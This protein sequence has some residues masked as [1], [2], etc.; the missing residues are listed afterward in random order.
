[1]TKALPII[2]AAVL[3]IVP[4]AKAEFNDFTEVKLNLEKRLANEGTSQKDSITIMLNLF[5]IIQSEGQ[6]TDS[7]TSAVLSTA[8]RSKDYGTAFDMLNNKANGSYQSI[9][10]L[11]SL[12]KIAESLPDHHRKQE[13]ISF[14]EMS[15]NY[16]YAYYADNAKRETRFDNQLRQI[17]L[18]PPKDLYEHIKVLHAI[19]LNLAKETRSDLT[20]KYF[21]DLLKL[22]D[23]APQD[24]RALR[25][26]ALVQAAMAFAVS[27]ESQRA[28]DADLKL[29]KI[30]EELKHEYNK[31]G[32][33]YRSFAPNKYI[34]YTRLLSNWEHLTPAQ[35]D[36]F[37]SEALENAKVDTRA[38]NTY[39]RY[40]TP[41][42]YYAMAHKDYAKAQQLIKDQIDHPYNAHRKLQ[43]LKYLITTSQALGDNATTLEA[44]LE[45]NKMLEEQLQTRIQEKY[46]ELQIVYETNAMREQITA[47][48]AEAK[49]K[50]ASFQHTILTICLI[51]L[52]GLLILLFFLVRQYRHSKHLT[53][54]LL[55]SNEAL[56]SE[57]CSLRA[58]QRELSA[59]RDAAQKAN[60][61][62]SDFIKN[63]SH[64]VS[65]PLNAMIEYSRLI[66]DCADAT[67][68]P[69]LEQYAGLVETNGE[70]LTSIINDIYHLAELDS[71]SVQLHPRF[72][73]LTELLTLTVQN[74]EMRARKGV[75]MEMDPD[76]EKI[77]I[78][79][80]PRRVQQIMLNVISNAVKFTEKGSITVDCHLIDDGKKVAIS[81]TDTGIGIPK[82]Q[83]EHIF[84]RYVKLDREAQGLGLGLTIAR[85]IARM[86]GGDLKLDTKYTHGARF[87][88][89]LPYKLK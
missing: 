2:A 27:D 3:A 36:E 56:K 17:T 55:A 62:K 57:S 58:S 79:T 75:K 31:Q 22:V 59:A 33:L 26:T 4:M 73:N 8:I 64:E 48:E 32:R 7:I 52:V 13:T 43:L 77:E 47:G 5:D 49:A 68:K 69:Y 10:K 16:Y 23:Q 84:D 82:E 70:F 89:T 24:Y 25:N 51:A 60:Q 41:D 42:I 12:L 37:Y 78:M 71:D 45:Y 86:L 6:S 85:M 15:R 14:I 19:S 39:D 65:T 40:H 30:I 9:E 72:T 54:T 18:Q 35:I 80:D 11:D 76:S 38:W 63:V 34:I 67:K 53:N 88:L 61:F 50:Q 29:L 46:K 1:M 44:S 20:I 74:L 28:I 83:A 87:V 21:D 66:V 81:F